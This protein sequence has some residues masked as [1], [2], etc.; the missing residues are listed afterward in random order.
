VPR[1]GPDTIDAMVDRLY[2]AALQH[3]GRAMDTV[4]SD[5]LRSPAGNGWSR[6]I[7]QYSQELQTPAL[8]VP[9]MQQQAPLQPET[10]AIGMQ[11]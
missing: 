4:A 7:Q 10:A 6:E 1:P 11:R 2:Q 8:P 3:D 5:Y 9:P